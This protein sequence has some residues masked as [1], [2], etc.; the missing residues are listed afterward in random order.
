MRYYRSNR[1]GSEMAFLTNVNIYEKRLARN[2]FCKYE[3]IGRRVLPTSNFW[4]HFTRFGG[5]SPIF[6]QN[7]QATNI[8]EIK[9]KEGEMKRTKA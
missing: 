9:A 2:I 4:E 8:G 3:V 5:Y 7:P 1:L 6:P